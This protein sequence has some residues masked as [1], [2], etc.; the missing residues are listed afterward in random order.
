MLTCFSFLTLRDSK[1]KWRANCHEKESY[2]IPLAK[3]CNEEAIIE[4]TVSTGV[5][6]IVA[7]EDS[8]AGLTTWICASVGD[9]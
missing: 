4:L 7:M 3:F 9:W 2:Q 1:G 6:S 5:E 8:V